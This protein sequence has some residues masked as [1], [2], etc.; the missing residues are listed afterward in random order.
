MSLKT[1]ENGANINTIT[2]DE[3]VKF[4]CDH[5]TANMI[6]TLR[7]HLDCLIEEKINYPGVSNLDINTEEGAVL[8]AIVKLLESE[9]F[10]AQN[11]TRDNSY[12]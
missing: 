4:D 9:V 12:E 11:Y 8:M 7:R 6:R 3:F 10:G 5:S 1:L 2:I